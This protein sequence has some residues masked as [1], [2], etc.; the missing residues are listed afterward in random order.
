MTRFVLAATLAAALVP[1]GI[2]HA[3]STC[4]EGRPMTGD[5]GIERYRCIGGACE[6]WSETSLGLTH[7]FT[8]EPR[9]DRLD[10]EGPSAGALRVGDV[11]VAIDGILITSEDGGQ[12]LANLRPGV[13]AVVWIRRGDRNLEVRVVP[14][15]GCNPSGLSV[16]IPGAS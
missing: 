8:T 1:G 4:P 3:Q 14:V 5:L 11:L 9:I 10:P 7:V 13:A 6:I 12:R 16:R 15:P 2:A